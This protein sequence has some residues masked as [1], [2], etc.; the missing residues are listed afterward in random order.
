MREVAWWR[1]RSLRRVA[2]VHRVL[3]SLA[4]CAALGAVALTGPPKEDLLKLAVAGLLALGALAYSCY[5]LLTVGRFMVRVMAAPRRLP[6]PPPPVRPAVRPHGGG[7]VLVLFP[8][9]GGPHARPEAVLPLIPPGPQ[10]QPRARLPALPVGTVGLHGWQDFTPDGRMP[11]VVPR[12][13]GRPLWPAGPYWETDGRPE[14]AA[15]LDRLAPP[16]ETRTDTRTETGDAA[17]T[18]TGA[19]AQES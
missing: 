1:V 4:F 18:E 17:R 16:L 8:V 6:A 13:G 9:Y 15:L 3:V 5:R 14:F 7:P 2:G 10:K 12:F 19:A 11:F